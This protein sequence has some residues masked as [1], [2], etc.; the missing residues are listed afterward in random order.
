MQFK[1][2]AGQD[3]WVCKMLNNK[4]NGFFIDV[5]ANDGISLSNTFALEKDL[6]WDGL[7]IEP[8]KRQFKELKKQRS[9][10]CIDK[11]MSFNNGIAKFKEYQGDNFAGHLSNEGYDVEVINFNKLLA[12]YEIPQEID[13]ISLDV[14]GMEFEI[15]IGFPFDEYDVK[16]WTIE[17]SSYNDLGCSNKMISRF[18]ACHGYSMTLAKTHDEG[19]YYK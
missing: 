15:L 19:F 6:A 17:H 16:L 4:A 10:I 1:S 7:C 3:H 12:D 9:C 13:Y 5:G 8:A 2:Q 14:E 11:A 18:M